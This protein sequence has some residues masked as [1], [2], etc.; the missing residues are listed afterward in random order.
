MPRFAIS[1]GYRWIVGDLHSHSEHCSDGQVSVLDLVKA[2]RQWCDFIG[3]SGHAVYED[4]WGAGQH[5]D[6]LRARQLYPDMPIFHTAEQE[7]P[8]PRHCMFIT[9]PD[10][11]ELE[12][13]QELIRRFDRKQGNVGIEKAVEALRF[14][15]KNW[16]RNRVFM[17]FNHPNAPDVPLDSLL[18]LAE[19]NGVFKVIAC[20]DRGE[21]RAEQTWGVN[22]EW[23]RLLCAGHRLYARCG[24]DFHQHFSKG[25]HDYYPGE[26]V[27]DVLLVK[28]N[29]YAD[30]LNAYRKGR[31]FCM[32]GHCIENPAFALRASPC[33]K[34]C[35]LSLSF[36]ALKPMQQI[37]I[38]SEGR[39]C[40]S[41]Y[42]VIGDF[43]FRG[44]F[45]AGSYFRVRGAGQPS[46]RPYS[47]GEY[48]P[49][50]L[51][52]PLFL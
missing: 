29:S 48:Q 27:Q 23:D 31:F 37:D 20:L 41:F 25:G 12:L 2:S 7:F 43:S 17:V 36:K 52:N 24:S 19:A 39:I 9:T 46:Q 18:P 3:I 4:N 42:D 22:T 16:G 35:Q 11:R 50:F 28:Q 49:V 32:C 15:E 26:F 6:I 8:V 10:N 47:E 1:K 14:V 38:I 40:A 45:P 51:L 30:I 33:G 13:Q 21:R 5:G 44:D 34:R